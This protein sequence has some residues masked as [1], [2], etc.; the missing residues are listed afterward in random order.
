MTMISNALPSLLVDCLMGSWSDVFG[1]RFP[2]FFP[3]VGGILSSIVYLLVVSL[4]SVG[5]EW[6]CLA[7]G[8]SGQSH[9]TSFIH[10]FQ[11]L[12]ASTRTN[13][14]MIIVRTS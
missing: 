3:A 7:S 9:N 13:T 12:C 10:L 4:D 5:V 14:F 11:G 6:L 2:L 8:L 1:R